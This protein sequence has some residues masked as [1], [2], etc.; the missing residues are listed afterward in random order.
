MGLNQRHWENFI[1]I[2]RKWLVIVIQD[3][4]SQ[5]GILPL[6]CCTIPL[7]HSL[8]LAGDLAPAMWWLPSHGEDWTRLILRALPGYHRAVPPGGERTPQLLLLHRGI[9]VTRAVRMEN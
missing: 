8:R 4:E 2:R 6:R 5:R 1:S 3:P 7:H 9:L